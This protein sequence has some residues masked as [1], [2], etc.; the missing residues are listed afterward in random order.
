MSMN[1]LIDILDIP[2]NKICF[3]CTRSTPV[4]ALVDFG[5]FLC[6]ECAS[7]TKES[8]IKDFSFLEL[9]KNQL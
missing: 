3:R 4:I 8:Y 6:S 5:I 2:E 7:P 9:E 1:Q